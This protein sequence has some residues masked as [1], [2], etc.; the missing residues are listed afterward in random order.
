M[1]DV[2]RLH[3]MFLVIWFGTAKTGGTRIL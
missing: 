1:Q 2:K 3:L